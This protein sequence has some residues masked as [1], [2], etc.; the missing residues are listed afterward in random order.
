[1]SWDISVFAA[2]DVPPPVEQMPPNWRGAVLGSNADVRASI[3][4][5][6]L[7]TD[8]SDPKWGYYRGA[9]FSLEFNLGSEEP[10]DGFMV[11]VRGS[12]EAVTHLLDLATSTGWF[13]LDCSD[14]EWLHHCEEPD[15][16]WVA[17][18]EY[19]DRVL[20]TSD[21]NEGEHPA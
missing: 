2:A 13:L 16:G 10:N 17:F 8:W 12:G 15:R 5:C 19:R 7:G 1:M 18:Q 14:G 4:A 9:D 21:P 20:R 11:H 3:S 6:L